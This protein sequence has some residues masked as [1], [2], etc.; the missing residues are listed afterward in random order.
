M[1]GIEKQLFRFESTINQAVL[2]LYTRTGIPPPSAAS[3]FTMD[4]TT[5]G[6]P[7][8]QGT[9]RPRMPT[10]ASRASLASGFGA[11]NPMFA[12][13]ENENVFLVYL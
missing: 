11:D 3:M 8:P 2:K 12:G 7:Y 1:D 6:L 4:S 5:G 10:N 9:P 13:G